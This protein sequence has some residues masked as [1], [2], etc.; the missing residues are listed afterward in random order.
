MS[1]RVRRRRHGAK[2]AVGLTALAGSAAAPAQAELVV[3][4]PADPGTVS[5]AS[6][7]AQ[8]SVSVQPAPSP[9]AVEVQPTPSS[10]VAP[11]P[12]TPPSPTAPA[13][14][15]APSPQTTA[16]SPQATVS[17]QAAPESAPPATPAASETPAS[18]NIQPAG[19]P[20]QAGSGSEVQNTASTATV[21][22]A[23]DP[24]GEASG[25][26][27]QSA[28]GAPASVGAAAGEGIAPSASV[29]SSGATIAPAS[30]PSESSGDG[31]Q[32][33]SPSGSQGLTVQSSSAPSTLSV[34]PSP[35]QPP[36]HVSAH[37]TGGQAVSG[38]DLQGG[39][40]RVSGVPSERG[41]SGGSV[42]GANGSDVEPSHSLQGSDVQPQGNSQAV[43]GKAGSGAVVQPA[44][45]GSVTT[46]PVP[47]IAQPAVAPAPSPQHDASSHPSTGG[48]TPCV[49]GTLYD[50][51]GG[52]L[53]YC[54]QA[55]SHTLTLILGVGDGG[56]VSIQ[57]ESDA[58]LGH[59]R[60]HSEISAGAGPV[61]GAVHG[62]LPL[63]RGGEGPSVGLSGG[64]TP[65]GPNVDLSATEKGLA[66]S[67]SL[68]QDLSKKGASGKDS[69]KSGSRSGS[70]KGKGGSQEGLQASA[71]VEIPIPQ[72]PHP[73]TWAYVVARP[74]GSHGPALPLFTGF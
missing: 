44:S 25:A 32:S 9:P 23:A 19:D 24:Q 42:G 63:G 7:E 33:G 55:R 62:D 5:V 52:G 1:S 54:P 21:Q 53:L 34:Q 65:F 22:S 73:R 39:P 36:I 8:P 10:S 67:G 46:K 4:Q 26:S 35:A 17:P 20:Q 48:E 71:A 28:A 15:A 66:L 38:T 69:T 49:S 74:F 3:S 43:Q 64:T 18:P 27:V 60:I 30:T 59:V 51:I 41:S 13:P 68:A 11:P 58:E 12:E 37:P 16:P 29:V 47:R 57:P 6:P 61:Q 56:A 45:G 72:V 2:L 31:S 70:S 40:P 50:G 14:E